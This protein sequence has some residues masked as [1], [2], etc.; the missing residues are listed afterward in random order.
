V[1]VHQLAEF[2]IYQKRPRL[3]GQDLEAE[4]GTI[5]RKKVHPTGVSSDQNQNLIDMS[6][7]NAVRELRGPKSETRKLAAG[8]PARCALQRLGNMT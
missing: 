1:P 2:E 4:V 7:A 5:S 3:L 8:Q 6:N